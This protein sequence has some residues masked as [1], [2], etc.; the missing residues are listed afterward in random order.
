MKEQTDKIKEIT[1]KLEQGIKGLFDSEDYK[2][3]LKAMSRFHS[4]S[5]N[6]SLLISMQKPDATYVAG[7]TSWEKS[8]HRHVRKGEQGIR[9]LAPSPYKISKEVEKTDP[10]THQP[11]IGNNGK[12][13]FER[14]QVIVPAYKVTNVFDISQTEGE[15]LP[16]I[17]NILS[18]DVKDYEKMMNAIQK[19][20]PVPIEIRKIEGGANGY[21]NPGD[22]HIVIKEGM[23]QTQTLKTAIHEVSHA[24]LHDKD[25]GL[26]KDSG[27]DRRTKEVQAESVA[28]TV[29]SHFGLDTSDYSFGYIA[30]WSKD[31]E[32]DELKKS[33]ETIRGT[34][35]KMINSIDEVLTKE[36]KEE[37]IENLAVD[38]NQLA[39]DYDY[40]GYMDAVD[41]S[42][43][44]IEEIKADIKAGN[45]KYLQ[46]SFKDLIDEKEP[47]EL[48]EKAKD[49]MKRLEK[50]SKED[51]VKH[52]TQ[53]ISK[54]RKMEDVTKHIPS[55][56]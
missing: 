35:S 31:K 40:Y 51:T 29:C 28:Y 1:E 14:V 12:P 26:L 10:Q 41:N 45:V 25:A 2:K 16:E 56:F 13:V 21:Y 47:K 33:M 46:D 11:I 43:K 32:L 20:S 3:Y 15:P 18:G 24:L 7:Y 44:M 34:A 49:I 22:K 6:N 8:F 9:I 42:E 23:S 52:M 19:T 53:E 27:L 50:Y 54:E 39:K 30:G 55:R 36:K 17:A 48:Y 37:K 4:Y 38:V 5:F